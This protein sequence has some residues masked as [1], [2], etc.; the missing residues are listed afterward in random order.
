ML[1]FDNDVKGGK[2]EYRC[3]L[4][5]HSGIQRDWWITSLYRC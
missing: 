4:W 1:G 2:R 5:R 3:V